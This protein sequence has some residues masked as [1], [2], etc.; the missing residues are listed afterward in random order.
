MLFPVS[1]FTLPQSKHGV[2]VDST[3]RYHCLNS[4]MIGLLVYVDVIEHKKLLLSMKN[5][6]TKGAVHDINPQVIKNVWP[7]LPPA[8]FIGVFSQ[9]S[10]NDLNESEEVTSLH[11]NTFN[12]N[13]QV[14]HV[15]NYMAWMTAVIL[16]KDSL[17]HSLHFLNI[18]KIHH[19]ITTFWVWR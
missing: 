9:Y 11:L 10:R 15:Q 14:S 8:L 13:T 12:V 19:G 3:I 16:S 7:S 6:S 2:Y 4:I 5:Y 1:I 17:C 18:K